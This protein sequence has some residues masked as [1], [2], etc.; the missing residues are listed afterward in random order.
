M[1]ARLFL[2]VFPDLV[3]GRAETATELR[4]AATG[5]MVERTSDTNSEEMVSGDLVHPERHE[6]TLVE[7][8]CQFR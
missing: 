1:S 2:A 7:S 4:K 5:P 6:T 8:K 3:L